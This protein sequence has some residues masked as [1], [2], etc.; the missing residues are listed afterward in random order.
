MRFLFVALFS[1]LALW[2][3]YWVLGQRFVEQ[4]VGLAL[5]GPMPGGV[6]LSHGGFDVAGFPSRFDLTLQSPQIRDEW[7]GWGWSGAFVQ[8]FAMTWKPWHVIAALP[9]EQSIATPFGPVDIASARFRASLRLSPSSDAALQEAVIEVE[10]AQLGAAFLPDIRLET[11]ILALRAEAAA[12]GEPAYRLGVNV[13]DLSPLVLEPKGGNLM[14]GHLD[15][16]LGLSAPLDRDAGQT[17]PF[18]TRL[19]LRALHLDWGDVKLTGSGAV[20]PGATG[21]AEGEISM[22]ITGWQDLPSRLADLALIQRP[23]VPTFTRALELIAK[24]QGNPDTMSLPLTFQNGWM[25]L[26][27]LPIGAAPLMGQRQ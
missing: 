2:A 27:N 18:V 25:R 11:L 12:Q 9:N 26:G 13:T 22:Q 15:A 7:T 1:A 17:M 23:M 6:Q 8:V 20:L 4:Q 5:N 19:N 14:A 21:R 10:A 24:E 3:G 16:V